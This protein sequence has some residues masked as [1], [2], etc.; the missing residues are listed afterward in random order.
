MRPIFCHLLRPLCLAL[1][2]SPL[3]CLKHPPPLDSL[4]PPPLLQHWEEEAFAFAKAQNTLFWQ[5]WTSGKPLELDS[6]YMQF[7]ALFS[8]STWKSMQSF[9]MPAPSLQ[10]CSFQKLQALVLG[11]LLSHKL[12]EQ[13]LAVALLEDNLTVMHQAR[14]FPWHELERL[15]AH[16]KDASHRKTLWLDSLKAVYPLGL[17]IQTRQQKTTEWLQY[18]GVNEASAIQLFREVDLEELSSRVQARL[19]KT[20]TQWCTQ[21]ETLAQQA[22]LEKLSQA[23]LP[24]FFQAKL[25]NAHRYFPA[26]QQAALVDAIFEKLGLW[27]TPQLLRHLGSTQTHPALPLVL[28]DGTA[29]SRLAFTPVQ[30]P[31]SLKQLLS[32]MGRA[33]SWTYVSQNHWACRHLGPPI[34]SNATA[35]LFAQLTQNKTWLVEQA[36][37]PHTAEAWEQV[38][39][40]QTEFEFRKTAAHFLAQWASLAQSPEE[41]PKTYAAMGAKVLCTQPLQEETA[42][43]R[44]DNEAFFAMA[45]KLRSTLL[46]EHMWEFLSQRFGQTWWH[47]PEAGAWLKTLWQEGNAV[48]AE[49]LLERFK[50]P[51]TSPL[52]AT[53]SFFPSIL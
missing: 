53:S 20:Q 12:R 13:N 23:D 4:A 26:N 40:A 38:L 5:H 16:E 47:Q 34:L 17:A 11:E 41:T 22:H 27:P 6:V 45:D 28:N 19:D 33:L 10:A 32:E 51:A 30:G 49:L 46:A 18:L 29:T 44:V 36:L 37:P 1:A 21:M 39:R 42:R 48:P 3:A 8:E 31:H 7:E 43:W 9:P 25:G 15:L 2:F 24:F 52:L 14:D 50:T 35:L